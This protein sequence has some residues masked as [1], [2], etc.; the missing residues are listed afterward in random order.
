MAGGSA[1]P[2]Q[3]PKSKEINGE[4]EIPVCPIHN[5]PMTK[6]KDEFGAFWSCHQGNEDVGFCSY[7][8]D[9]R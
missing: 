5:Q 1:K 7:R 9:C 4:G 3:Q 8:P 2:E 6:E